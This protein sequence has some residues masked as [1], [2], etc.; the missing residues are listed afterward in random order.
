MY[1]YNTQRGPLVLKE[2]GRNIQNL[3]AYLKS[4]DDSEKRSR[5]GYALVELMKQINPAVRETHETNQKLW[6]D[7]HIMSDF[8]LEIEGPFPT[9]DR[10]IL[11][12]KP[13]RM[14]YP[15]HSP[16]F[17]HYGRNLELL[18]AEALKKETP[19]EREASVIYIGKMMKSFAATWN[20]D[21][22]DEEVIVE[23]IRKLSNGELTIDV[24]KVKQYHLFDVQQNNQNHRQNNSG[25]GGGRG[26]NNNRGRRYGHH[27]RRRN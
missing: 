1:D 22:L 14:P 17:K 23:Q 15:Q 16:R 18:I 21:N 10:E 27:K 24:E 13:L 20:K 4:V 19:E 5:H 2:Y 11:D 6:D 12:K 3:V 8:T 7:M 9:P 26:G 25:G